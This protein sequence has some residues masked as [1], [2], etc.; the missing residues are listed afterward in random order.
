M[1]QI[2]Q[3]R[4]RPVVERKRLASILLEKYLDRVPVL[5]DRG[6]TKDPFPRKSKYIIDGTTTFGALIA[7]IRKQ[8]VIPAGSGLF[9]YTLNHKMITGSNLVVTVYNEFKS[10]DGFLYIL[11]TLENTFG[12]SYEASAFDR[13]IDGI[14]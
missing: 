6:T 13:F 10:D 7:T 2:K 8:M 11:Y 5:V 1:E 3:F 12:S 4:L 14:N 9:A